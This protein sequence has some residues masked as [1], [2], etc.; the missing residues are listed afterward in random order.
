MGAVSSDNTST[1]GMWQRRFLAL[2][3]VAEMLATSHAQVYALV[4]SG[5]LPAIKVGGRGQWRVEQT[6]LDAWIASR[7]EETAAFVA[8]NPLGGR[9]ASDDAGPDGSG[10]PAGASQRRGPTAPTPP[11]NKSNMPR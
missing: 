2:G 8:A 7:Y 6:Q 4:R 11:A 1:P 5:D 9:T 3:Q 10:A